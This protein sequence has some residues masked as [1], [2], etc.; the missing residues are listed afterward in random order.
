MLITD[1]VIFNHLLENKNYSVLFKKFKNKEGDYLNYKD[2]FKNN[3]QCIWDEKILQ[4]LEINFEDNNEEE[5]YNA[6]IELLNDEKNFDQK[7]KNYFK[8]NN[9]IFPYFDNAIVNKS[10]IFFNKKNFMISN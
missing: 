2:I 3:L 10:S 7:I 4:S 6:L 9:I 1:C 5:V 8:K